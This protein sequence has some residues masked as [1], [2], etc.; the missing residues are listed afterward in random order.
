LM[1]SIVLEVV[2]RWPGLGYTLLSAIQMRDTAVILGALVIYGFV[3]AFLA[4]MVFLL[5]FLDVWLMQRR[6]RV[7]AQGGE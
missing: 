2:F 7:A 5:D 6:G 4:V 3:L 1:G